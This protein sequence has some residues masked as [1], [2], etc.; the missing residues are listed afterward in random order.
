LMLRYTGRRLPRVKRYV[1]VTA[2]SDDN[3]RLTETFA[4]TEYSVAKSGLTVVRSW[5]IAGRPWML[6]GS[7]FGNDGANG[8]C[9]SRLMAKY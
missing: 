9:A 3:S 4:L 2:R 1:A 5:V 6:V 8:C 7:T